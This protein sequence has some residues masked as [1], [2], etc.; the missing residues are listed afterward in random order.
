[1]PIILFILLVTAAVFFSCAGCVSAGSCAEKY[2]ASSVTDHA[3]CS[4]AEESVP[5]TA[6]MYHSVLKSRQ[7]T[8]IV[9]PSRLESDLQ[10]FLSEGYTAVFPSE[11]ASYAQGRGELPDKPLLITFDDGHYNNLYYALPLLRKYNM[12]ATLNVIGAFT[13]FSTESG[14]SSN[15]N[16]SHVTWDEIRQAAESGYIE[17]GNHTYNM[18]KYKPRFGIGRMSG[19]SEEDYRT[20][21]TADIGRLQNILTE[22]CGCTPACFAYPFG[23]YTDISAQVLREMGFTVT[24]T[25]NEGVTVVRK[26]QPDSSFYIRRINMDGTASTAQLMSKIRRL[27]PQGN[28]SA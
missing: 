27:S 28:K 19:E 3:L 7:G 23:K 6:V 26:G 22:K 10:A 14:D 21:I 12:K 15:P 8:Y 16:Y 20:A 17:I 25:C 1:M 11:V 4:S 5:V 2:S 13:N 9:S 18:H 24:L